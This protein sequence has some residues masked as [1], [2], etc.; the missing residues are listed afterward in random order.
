MNISNVNRR[1]IST[2]RNG[3]IVTTKENSGIQNINA[4]EKYC[5]LDFFKTFLDSNNNIIKGTDK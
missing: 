3:M 5:Y 1:A 4:L 2:G